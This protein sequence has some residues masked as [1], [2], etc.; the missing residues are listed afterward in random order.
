V[1]VDGR[2]PSVG[3][4]APA[5]V[6]IDPALTSDPVPAPEQPIPTDR[7]ETRA[8]RT[9]RRRRLA[10]VLTG[11]LA[12]GLIVVAVSLAWSRGAA[13]P[14]AHAQFTLG[15]RQPGYLVTREEL[16][17]RAT[18]AAQGVEPYAEAVH[19]LLDFA[20]RAR[21]RKPNPQ[22]PLEI[23]GTESP[24]LDDAV[25]TYGLA[26]AYGLTGERAYAETAADYLRAWSTTT[27]TTVGTCPD[28]GACQTSLIMSRAAP[29]Y[30]FAADL[31]SDTGAL[32][33][34]DETTFR[35]WLRDVIL[36]TA[37][38]LANNWG[39]AGVFTRFVL[40]DYLGDR[41]GTLRAL[42]AWLTQLDRIDADGHLPEETRRGSAGMSYTQEAL[43]Y[44]VAVAAIAERYGL[45]LWRMRGAGGATLVDAIDYLASY[46]FRP[47]DWP[48]DPDVSTPSTGP[49]WEIAYARLGDPA[50]EP[51]I[52][53]RRPFSD[54]GHSA[55]RWT[56]LT[57]GVPF[58]SASPTP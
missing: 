49:F 41:D 1:I 42:D 30:V 16:Q 18:L 26:L 39:D 40:N 12:I 5:N 37:P 47:R 27:R 2:L 25:R 53:D 22:E 9:L 35:A 51:I 50:F 6:E 13:E 17:R 46:W 15:P 21:S 48:W 43:Q 32:S 44:R 11:L 23:T 7:V 45:D 31:I 52:A 29:A 56:T 19:E 58:G 8:R 4:E 28:S 55:L 3:E 10:I 36:P 24:F 33:E 20:D 57:D 14:F 54:Q 38:R 34:A